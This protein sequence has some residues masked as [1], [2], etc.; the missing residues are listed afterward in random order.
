MSVDSILSDNDLT[1]EAAYTFIT[2]NLS[3]PGV[4]Y[5]AA[6]NAGLT[7]SDLTELITRFDSSISANDVSNFFA[8]SGLNLSAIMESPGQPTPDETTDSG[9]TNIR[10]D[11]EGRL[12][13]EP[14]E[15]LTDE[16]KLFIGGLE[17][18]KF[19]SLTFGPGQSDSIVEST[20][21]G[22]LFDVAFGDQDFKDVI[23]DISSQTFE[24]VYEYTD[25]IMG[26]V[27]ED[28]VQRSG[29]TQQELREIYT[30]SVNDTLTDEQTQDF[31]D[32]RGAQQSIINEAIQPM[33]E[34]LLAGESEV[35]G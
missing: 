17:Q 3:A 1:A 33:Y 32:F 30:A 31:L 6:I 13:I 16:Q 28:A 26:Q 7:V 34:A 24:S 12:V 23:F 11:A 8:N 15:P 27:Q 21:E 18:A 35:W 19:V 2:S 20:P 14:Q 22:Y 29:V 5:D 4:V 10:T 25:P 9:S